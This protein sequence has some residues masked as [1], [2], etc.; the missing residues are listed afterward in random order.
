M[1]AGHSPSSYSA[2]LSIEGIDVLSFFTNLLIVTHILSF[3]HQGDEVRIILSFFLG[4][5]VLEAVSCQRNRFF[6]KKTCWKFVNNR[7]FAL[8]MR[9]RHP[10]MSDF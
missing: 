3:F 10:L 8:S 4:E 1:W 2:A 9:R 6:C 7:I 5:I